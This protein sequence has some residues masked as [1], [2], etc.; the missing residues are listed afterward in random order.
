[1]KKLLLLSVPLLFISIFLTSCQQQNMTTD[2]S[3]AN[4]AA[5]MKIYE[6]FN[7]GNADSLDNYVAEDMM[8]HAMDTM[9]TK[10]QGVA[11]LKETIVILRGAF[12]DLNFNVKAMAASGDTVLSY[13]TMTGTNSGMMMGM[14]ATNK[15]I[16]I[17]GA[18]LVI[19][20]EGKAV[21]HWGVEDDLGMMKQ[22]GLMPP[23]PGNMKHDNMN[24]KKVPE[25]KTTEKPM[26]KK[27]D[28]TKKAN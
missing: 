26:N 13:I 19:F 27:P 3:A 7:T 16:N 6:A 11:G 23:P 18:D 22:L 1:M 25:K 21:E 28:K 10:K 15:S 4:K 5:M 12:P 2:N 9:I 14:P 20:K 24:M 17:A 8:D